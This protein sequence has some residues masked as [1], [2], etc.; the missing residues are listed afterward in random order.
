MVDLANMDPK[1]LAE[2]GDN[3]NQVIADMFNVPIMVAGGIHAREMFGA[4]MISSAAL[5]GCESGLSMME[6]IAAL[7]YLIFYHVDKRTTKLQRLR[8]KQLRRLHNDLKTMH[9]KTFSLIKDHVDNQ[10]KEFEVFS[11]TLLEQL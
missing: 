9:K 4:E 8:N 5:A 2:F 6:A 7:S 10:S 3:L 1:Y 11:K